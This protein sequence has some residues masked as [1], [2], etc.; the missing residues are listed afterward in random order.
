M[1]VKQKYFILENFWRAKIYQIGTQFA[2]VPEGI[3]I[4][5]ELWGYREIFWR[6][7]IFAAQGFLSA[8]QGKRNLVQK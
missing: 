3:M 4:K 2:R 7:K 5:C 8:A 1:S 6:A